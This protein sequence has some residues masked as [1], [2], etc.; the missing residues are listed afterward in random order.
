MNISISNQRTGNRKSAFT[1]V[2]VMIASTI[3]MVIMGSAV[4]LLFYTSRESSH[5][6]G[7]TSVEQRAYTLQ[8]TIINTIRGMSA[9]TGMSP[10]TSTAVT[11]AN[12]NTVGYK[13]ISMFSQNSSGVSVQSKLYFDDTSNNVVFV[14]DM[15]QASTKVFWATNSKYCVVRNLCF[16]GSQNMDGSPNNALVNVI[17]QMDDNGYSVESTNSNASIV[18]RTFS[19]LMKA[20]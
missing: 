3:A 15:T 1:F 20:N 6:M 10:D 9:A 2:E 5:N 12:G 13:T 8:N 16:Q 4:M 7:A 14:P 11:D 18:Y 17:L 19:V